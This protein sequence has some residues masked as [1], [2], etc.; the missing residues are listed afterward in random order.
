MNKIFI[1]LSM[2]GTIHLL[3]FQFS[4][5]E[6]DSLRKNKQSQEL[7]DLYLRISNLG[8]TMPKVS[9]FENILFF[10]LSAFALSIDPLAGKYPSQ[11]PYNAM[12]NNSINYVDPDGRALLA[13][14]LLTPNAHAPTDKED[15]ANASKLDIQRNQMVGMTLLAAGGAAIA[16]DAA[17]L[18][19]PGVATWVITNPYSTV[20]IGGDLAVACYSIATGEQL[21]PNMVTSEL[22]L[23]SYGSR[24]DEYKQAYVKATQLTKQAGVSKIAL[25]DAILF[26]PESVSIP[27]LYRGDTRAPSEIFEN[28]FVVRGGNMEDIASHLRWSDKSIFISTSIDE[29]IALRFAI[30]GHLYILDGKVANRGINLA[31][32]NLYNVFFDGLGA[33]QMEVAVKGYI[34]NHLIKGAYQVYE[35]NGKQVLGPF[36]PNPNYISE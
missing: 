9:P 28:G 27:L 5:A 23:I 16:V 17:L 25:E 29:K 21:P 19:G 31:E 14:I 24:L 35:D 6:N 1:F 11:S 12:G 22:S 32:E 3:S 18:F 4:M 30:K 20:G 26:E 8:Y 34:P 13:A 2:M 33:Y 15:I 10:D 7:E 36:I